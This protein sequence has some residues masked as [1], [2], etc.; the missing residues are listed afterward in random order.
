MNEPL[1]IYCTGGCDACRDYARKLGVPLIVPP[2]PA[3]P[4]PSDEREAAF[5]EAV[6]GCIAIVQQSL[7]TVR[8]EAEDAPES[9][10]LRTSVS[11]REHVIA[12][13]TGYRTWGLSAPPRSRPMG[14]PQ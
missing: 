9:R 1:P 5:L 14:E 6:D 11:A 2:P 3:P 4:E 12:L 13:L 8:G 7:S 10:V